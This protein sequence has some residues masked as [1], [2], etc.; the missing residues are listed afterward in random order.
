MNSALGSGV[1]SILVRVWRFMRWPLAVFA[2]LYIGL[3]IYELTQLPART[4]TALA[5][6]HSQK[7][8]MEDVDG[9]HLP[10]PPD[11]N[12]V[13][14]TVEGIDANENGIRDDVELAIFKKYPND[15]KLR[16]AALQYAMTNQMFLT[17]VFNTE[18]W[19]AVAEE[20][21]RANLCVSESSRDYRNAVQFTEDLDSMLLNTEARSATYENVFR[22]TTSHGDGNGK[23]C[24][25]QR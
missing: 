17:Q 23:F 20:S 24:D 22:F 3:I 12:L 9:K 14:A 13:D 16:A 21:G 8:T 11:P 4:E 19:K 5:T 7:L 6:I 2:A 1:M 15:M 18:T 10:P 25:V